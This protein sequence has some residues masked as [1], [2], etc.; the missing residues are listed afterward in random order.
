MNERL[1]IVGATARPWIHSSIRAGFDVSAFDFFAD[2]DAQNLLE[3]REKLLPGE[4]EGQSNTIQQISG[5][6]H[7]L[8]QAHEP[9][10]TSCNS[11]LI[12]GGFESRIDLVESLGTRISILG[13]PAAQLRRLRNVPAVMEFLRQQDVLIPATKSK[14][15]PHD[16]PG[17]WLRKSCGTAGGTGIRLARLEDV[18]MDDPDMY[19]QWKADGASVSAVLVSTGDRHGGISTTLLGI[20]E[21]AVGDD[22]FGANPFQYCG[23]I[24]PFQFSEDITNQIESVGRCLALEFEI[25]GLW[26]IDFVVNDNGAMPVDFNPRMTASMELYERAVHQCDSSV[27]SMVD[28]HVKAS[29]GDWDDA[30]I[31]K[32]KQATDATRGTVEGKSI[33]FHRDQQPLQ[34]SSSTFAEFQKMFEASFFESNEP[35]FSIADVPHEG[36]MIK[37]GHPILSLRVRTKRDL[38]S[39]ELR[40]R[41]A[42]IFRLLRGG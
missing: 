24:G 17:C 5:F 18:G 26:G 30:V 20:T 34:I 35:G 40:E 36:Q 10:I 39:V 6:E 29:R 1:L 9:A 21:Q 41:A 13:P 19:F 2:W 37:I 16:E 23:S 31:R 14:L 33:L 15:E 11:A 4:T 12:C 8:D 42:T 22:Q 32:V 27:R 38:V 7:L 25:V 3:T 28:L